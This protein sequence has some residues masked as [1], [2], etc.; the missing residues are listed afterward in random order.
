[1]ASI[2]ERI[3]QAAVTALASPA[4]ASLPA[5]QVFRDYEYAIESGLAATIVVDLGDETPPDGTTGYRQRSV[6]L[7][8]VI[9]TKGATA[10][11]S[12]D[13]I[14]VEAHG[15]IMNDVTLQEIT[16]DLIEDETTRRSEV[17]EKPVAETVK[18]YRCLYR[19][20]GDSLES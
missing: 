3:A 18:A 6:M 9:L 5:A 10:K 14:L 8:V 12:A 11:A 20:T 19:T 16:L 2:A 15:R 17:L 13:P 1:M 4:M 7:R